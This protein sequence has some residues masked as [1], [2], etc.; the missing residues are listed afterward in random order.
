MALNEMIP[1]RVKQ[2]EFVKKYQPKVITLTAG[3]NDAGFGAKLTLCANHESWGSS[4]MWAK[5]EYRSWLKAD[6]KYQYYNLSTRISKRQP[7]IKQ[8]Y[9][10]WVI[11]NLSM[12][13]QLLSVRIPLR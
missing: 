9:M 4:C 2:I 13:I 10:F 1:G 5:P 6:L 12:A 11:H 8:R 7:M 3:G